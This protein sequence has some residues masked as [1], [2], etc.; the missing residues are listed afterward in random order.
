MIAHHEKHAG[1][2]HKVIAL[3]VIG[4]ID[5]PLLGDAIGLG[6]RDVWKII[7]VGIV[8][9]AGPEGGLGLGLRDSIE[10]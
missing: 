5:R 3:D 10:G 2:N 6:G 9:V 1:R 4:Q 7:D 8:G